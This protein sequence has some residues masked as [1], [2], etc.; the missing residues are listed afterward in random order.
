VIW[1]L[2]AALLVGASA[3]VPR[4]DVRAVAPRGGLVA[5]A[6]VSVDVDH[7]SALCDRS[8]DGRPAAAPR[9]PATSPVSPVAAVP[10]Y[11]LHHVYRI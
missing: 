2:A 9:E 7:A 1:A 11:A 3:P 4:V 6:D 10:L 5:S 8:A